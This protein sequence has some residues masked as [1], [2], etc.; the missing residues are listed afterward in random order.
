MSHMPRAMGGHS[1]RRAEKQAP[2]IRWQINVGAPPAR[3]GQPDLLIQRGYAWRR[4]GKVR[5]MSETSA[6]PPADRP[7]LR[8]RMAEQWDSYELRVIPP[9]AGGAQ[10][11]ET[12]RAFY[13]GAQALMG[14]VMNSL[15]P[16]SEPT[17]EDVAVMEDLD[18]ELREF[19]ANVKAGKA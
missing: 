14:I 6:T 9:A 8:Q 4:D 12:R 1:E 7:P 16:E 17:D 3:T 2:R 5:T 19:V 11:V 15:S 13:A 10:R 18:A